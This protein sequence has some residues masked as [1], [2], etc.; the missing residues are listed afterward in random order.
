M[1]TKFSVL[2]TLT[3]AFGMLA[4]IVFIKPTTQRVM[5]PTVVHIYVA[6]ENIEGGAKLTPAQFTL[7]PWPLTR[8]PA[9]AILEVEQFDHPK[10]NLFVGEPLRN[11]DYRWTIWSMP[12]TL[13]KAEMER[14]IDRENAMPPRQQ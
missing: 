5:K 2:L 7:K 14:V 4:T 8:L 1:R 6:K 11:Q 10:Q 12:W 9:D 3:F 13:S